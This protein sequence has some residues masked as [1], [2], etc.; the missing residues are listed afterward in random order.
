MP[1]KVT[2]MLQFHRG[3]DEMRKFVTS[4]LASYTDENVP[5]ARC[6]FLDAKK[7]S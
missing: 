3:K 1:P 6:C 5:S 2:M 7:A 4:S